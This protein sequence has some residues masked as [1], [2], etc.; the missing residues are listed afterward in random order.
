MTKRKDPADLKIRARDDLTIKPRR[1][2]AAKKSPEGQAK[3]IAALRKTPTNGG[4]VAI[5]ETHNPDRPLTEKQKLFVKEWAGGESILSASYRA[6]YSD[7]GTM[8]YRLAKDPAILKIYNVE[9]ALY[10]EASQMTRKRV[11]E[12]FLEAADM[13]RTLAD[14]TALTGAWREV[15]KMCGYYEP[16]KRTIDINIS[17]DVT[18]KK[19]ERLSDAE[20]L[21]LVKG[22]VE[23]VTFT[24]VAEAEDDD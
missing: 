6:G 19:L 9:K 17:G 15:G 3:R 16:V 14:P 22:E 7:N 11:M 23:D 13:A 24:E 1:K 4:N 8:A 20:L 18:M 2:S 10:E 21:Q 12:G 5:I